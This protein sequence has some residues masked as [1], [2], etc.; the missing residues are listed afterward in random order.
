MKKFL[1]ASSAMLGIVAC[2][3]ASMDVS[4]EED[5]AFGFEGPAEDVG[6]IEYYEGGGWRKGTACRD[7]L[8]ATGN[9][10]GDVTEDIT[11]M[12]QFGEDVR[13]Y[14]FCDRAVL[15]VSGAFW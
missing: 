7:D 11:L 6:S 4:L 2:A 3:P 5:G 12:D 15:I 8:S 14:D 10:V 13:L 1:L 9:A